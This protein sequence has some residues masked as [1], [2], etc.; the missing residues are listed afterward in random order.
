[1]SD[2]DKSPLSTSAV[3]SQESPHLDREWLR[4]LLDEL[5]TFD[6]ESATQGEHDAAAWIIERLADEEVEGL[7]EVEQVHGTY[8]WPLGLGVAAGAIAGIASLK[9]RT[10]RGRLAAAG[11]AG[12][13]AAGIASD[14]PP[15]P[16]WIRRLLPKRPT[17][18]VVAELGPPDAEKTVVIVAH[19]DSAH[20]GLLF[21]PAVPDNLSRR[22]PI[23]WDDAETSPP[24]MFPVLGGPVAVALG[25]LIGSRLLTR[26]GTFLSAGAVPVFADI[27]ARPAVP[28]AND[29][30][31]A[32]VLLLALARA[33]KERPTEKLRVM[34]VSTGSEESFSEGMKAFGERHF[35]ELPPESTFF[36]C[37]DTLGSPH[38]NLLHGEGFL[39]M[40][41]YPADLIEMTEEIARELGIW[42]YPNL[43]LH[44]GTDGLESLVAGYPTIS[45]CSVTD[46]KAPANYHWKT[47]TP[48]QVDYGTLVD[49]IRLT[50]GL[51]RRL[52]Q[53]WL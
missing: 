28:G 31:T 14:Y 45:M 48:D 41:E 47:D 52:D 38:L 34:L 12:A 22:F 15:G 26:I 1:M 42:L 44:N 35:P 20:A 25:S 39:K 10:R 16:R 3:S 40:H 4:R 5:C 46:Y 24:M 32:V 23:L 51:V 43:R 49:A 6:R 30:G 19:H 17:H 27:G 50:E 33:L 37:V 7:V 2:S 29:N 9:A 13:A 18:N 21:H 36:C 11:L 8:W 53:R